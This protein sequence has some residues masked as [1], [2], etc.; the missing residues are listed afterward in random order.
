MGETSACPSCSLV[1][2]Q[3][4]H[5]AYLTVFLLRVYPR[6]GFFM[7][8]AEAGRHCTVQS[9]THSWLG[10]QGLMRLNHL[11]ACAALTNLERERL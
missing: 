4:K 10:C 9:I 7:A 2:S 1:F 5:H 6:R 3:A 11:E 8:R